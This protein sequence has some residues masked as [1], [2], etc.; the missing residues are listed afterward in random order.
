MFQ[1]SS[2]IKKRKEEK[3]PIN[4]VAYSIDLNTHPFF[5]GMHSGIFNA[6][7]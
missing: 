5:T 3:N 4:N 7:L 1:Q 6:P 2:F